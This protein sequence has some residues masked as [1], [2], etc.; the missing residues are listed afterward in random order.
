MGIDLRPQRRSPGHYILR[1]LSREMPLY[2]SGRN[3]TTPWIGL[4]QPRAAARV[5][6]F[7]FPFAGGGASRYRLW[8]SGLPEHID[9]APVQP[10]GREDRFLEDPFHCM[11]DLIGALVHALLPWMGE[12]PFAFFGHSLGAIVALEAS[13]ALA[14]HG[15]HQPIHV[16]VSARAA[17]HLPLRRDP[18]AGLSR[19]GLKQWLRRMNGTPDAVLQSREMMDMILPS[20]RADLD[21][22]DRYRSTADPPL[23]CPLTVLGGVGDEEATPAELQAWSSYTTKTF[24]FRL[25]EGGHFFAFNQGRAAALAAIAEALAG[26]GAIGA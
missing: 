13:R 16:I 25:I 4:H 12:L 2:P 22:D 26:V 1:H 5:R 7:C 6:L 11:D 24:A 8:S 15:A 17:P 18:V 21:L 10:P 9:V 3:Y 14:L 19:E 23:R 20:L